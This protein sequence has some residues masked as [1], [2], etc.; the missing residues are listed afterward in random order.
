[1]NEHVKAADLKPEAPSIYE[2]GFRV[3][4]CREGSFVVDAGRDYAAGMR[5]NERWAFTSIS[6]MLRFL[7]GEALVPPPEQSE[8]PFAPAMTTEQA[9]QKIADWCARQDAQVAAV[10]LTT[11]TTGAPRLPQSGTFCGND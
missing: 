11:P 3:I 8:L 4:P 1:M 10:T 5:T 7:Q 6:D 9:I 2:N